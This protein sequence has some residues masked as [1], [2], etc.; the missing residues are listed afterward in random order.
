MSLKNFFIHLVPLFLLTIMGCKFAQK[1]LIRSAVP[2]EVTTTVPLPTEQPTV[3]ETKEIQVPTLSQDEAYKQY[4]R[5]L[6][7]NA[8]C[9][10]PCWWGITPGKT[11]WRDAEGF[12]KAF[13]ELNTNGNTNGF[14][15][16]D[17]HLPLPREKGTLSH[18]YYIKDGIVYWIEAYNYDWAPSLFLTEFLNT[19]GPPNEVFIRTF[20]SEEN[21]SQPFLIDLFYGNRGILMEYSGGDPDQ[22]DSKL[23]DC[24][25]DMNAPFI[26]LWSPDE[27]MTSSEAI[28]T[29]LDTRNLPYPVPI[30]KSSDMDISTFF[31]IFKNPIGVKCIDTPLELW[32]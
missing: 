8:G 21:G 6:Q 20:R 29:F 23:R 27:K 5:L 12:L 30:I 10:L 3:A 14:F 16:V 28:N 18:T 24:F 11:T 17:V 2:T 15:A 31:N 13:T 4:Q 22:V 25:N 32:P 26:Y 9:Q 1:N 19:F 7:N